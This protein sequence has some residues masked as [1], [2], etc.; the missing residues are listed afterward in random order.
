MKN[1]ADVGSLSVWDKCGTETI[2]QEIGKDGLGRSGWAG[3]MGCSTHDKPPRSSRRHCSG[4]GRGRSRP[5]L[6]PTA[7]WCD[8][9]KDRH[10]LSGISGLLATQLAPPS[11]WEVTLAFTFPSAVAWINAPVGPCREQRPSCW[12]LSGCHVWLEQGVRQSKHSVSDRGS[13]VRALQRVRAPGRRH[14]GSW[15]QGSG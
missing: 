3:V 7:P 12:V 2:L 10:T 13:G 4:V 1:C 14:W 11:E 6:L 5:A 15:V 9:A 8:L